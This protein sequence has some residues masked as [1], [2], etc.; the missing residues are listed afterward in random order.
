MSKDY[1][2]YYEVLRLPK[3]AGPDDIQKNWKEWAALMA[4][5]NFINERMKARAEHE[6]KE[7]NVARDELLAWWRAR[8]C[9]PP[10][11]FNAGASAHPPPQPSPPQPK[12]NPKP[13][14]KPQP[15][16]EPKP[17][18]K[19]SSPPPK[20]D[21]K[22]GSPPP[23]P[24]RSYSKESYEGAYEYWRAGQ[25]SE[26]EQAASKNSNPSA[27][28]R[29]FYGPEPIAKSLKLHIYDLMIS[30]NSAAE[31]P[32]FFAWL[33]FY[34]GPVL[35][36]VW[37]S[38]FILPLLNIQP[39]PV[40]GALAI[41]AS[42]CLA[43]PF[44]RNVSEDID[45]YQIRANP[46]LKGISGRSAQETMS[47]ISQLIEGSSFAGRNWQLVLAEMTGADS[48]LAKNWLLSFSQN[49]RKYMVLLNVR[50]M[51]PSPNRCVL[52]FWFEIDAPHDEHLLA[53]LKQTQTA[54]LQR[55]K[56]L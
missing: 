36:F 44:W 11:R 13:N 17:H 9:P 54:F 41:I 4:P 18:A 6:Q 3:G 53:P 43:I 2:K 24:E 7:I 39:G 1:D 8:N 22:P 26:N 49:Q 16:P 10:T 33:V 56:E 50:I 30:K 52:S 29:D 32:S 37:L 27:K 46:V 38:A 14:P 15:N 21:V 45:V 35:G 31:G 25:F 5:T 12:P 23:G 51:N 20:P 47:S 42:V 34:F 40:S 28:T 48:I 55:L 19:A